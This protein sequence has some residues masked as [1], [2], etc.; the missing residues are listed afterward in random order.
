[1]AFYR[2][3]RTAAFVP[4]EMEFAFTLDL[5][6]APFREGIHGRNA[7][8]MQPAG[9]LIPAAVKLSACMQ[10]GHDKFQSRTLLRGMFRNRDTAPIIYHGNAFVLVNG[11]INL[12]AGSS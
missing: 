9:N 8:T 6:F 5:H 7:D 12:I 4:L 11:D 10:C 2:S 3:L 1:M